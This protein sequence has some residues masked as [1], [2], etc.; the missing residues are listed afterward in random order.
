M[1]EQQSDLTVDVLLSP[2]HGSRTSSSPAFLDA[3]DPALVIV[4]AGKYGKK[5]YPAPVNIAA[6]S[7][8]S[9]PVAVTRDQGTIS[10]ATEGDQ[11]RCLDFSGKAV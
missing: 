2:H 4:S 10:C 11:L 8:R 6:W 7:E 5:Y 3:V 9:I 1:L